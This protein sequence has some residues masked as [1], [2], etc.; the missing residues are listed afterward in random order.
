MSD[1]TSQILTFMDSSKTLKPKY[2]ESK[3]LL[4]SNKKNYYTL[5]STILQE[6]IF[7]QRKPLRSSENKWVCEKK[8][9]TSVQINNSLF[10]G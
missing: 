4:F 3:P 1:M 5:R 6:I 2:R 7:Y 10:S 8:P 9:E